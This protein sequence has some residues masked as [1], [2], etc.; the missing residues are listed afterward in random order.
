MDRDIRDIPCQ[1]HKTYEDKDTAKVEAYMVREIENKCAFVLKIRKEDLLE[2]YCEEDE[3]DMIDASMCL[4]GKWGVW[5]S[6]WER[7][8]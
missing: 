3:A 4:V 1:L 6:Y 2:N 8:A 7:V 5:V